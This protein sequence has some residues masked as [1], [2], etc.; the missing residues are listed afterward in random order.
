MATQFAGMQQ[1]INILMNDPNYKVLRHILGQTYRVHV[2]LGE[3]HAD[4]KTWNTQEALVG[5]F[6]VFG[7][8]TAPGSENETK[9]GKCKTDAAANTIITGTVPLTAQ[10]ISVRLIFFHILYLLSILHVR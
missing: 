9:C 4:T 2:F 3:F 1:N 7:K 6:A 5:T 10:I 8:E